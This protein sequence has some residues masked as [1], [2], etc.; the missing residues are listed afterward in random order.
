M[1]S[2]TQPQTKRDRPR[3]KRR[4][5]SS[6]QP[7]DVSNHASFRAENF[8]AEQA[9]WEAYYNSLPL[10][11]EDEATK[12]FN[13]EWV[14]H[15]SA[16]LPPYSKVLEAGCGAGWQSLAL[17]RTGVFRVSLMD[18]TASA[19]DYARRLFDREKLSADFISHNALE[20]GHPEFDLVF[21]AGVIEHYTFDQQ[22]EFVRAMASRSR[23]YVA[24]LAP[25]RLCYWYWLWRI[26]RAGIGQWPFGREVPLVDF[27]AMF[28]AAGIR[29]VGQTF[30]GQT[31]TEG[32]IGGADGMDPAFRH[33]VLQV[34][35]SLVIPPMHKAY[36]VAALGCVSPQRSVLPS[37]W[38][39][40]KLGEPPSQAEATAAIADAL[41]LR[42]AGELTENKLR[43]ELASQK[44]TAEITAAELRSSEAKRNEFEKSAAEQAANTRRA[45]DQAAQREH[46]LQGELQSQ[47]R[48]AEQI[49]ATLREREAELS[50]LAGKLSEQ[51][52]IAR[53][54]ADQIAQN[55]R[56]W[57][58]QK[59]Q[60]DDKLRA[61]ERR[62]SEASRKLQETS[63]LARQLV[64][65][66]REL[67]EGRATLEASQRKV[68]WLTAALAADR[69]ARQLLEAA[70]ASGYS[71]TISRIREVVRSS[72]PS[73]ATVLV[74]SRGDPELIKFDGRQAWHFPRSDNGNYAG[75]H[76]AE[77]EAAVAHLQL[78]IAQGGQ[79]LIVPNTAFWWLEHYRGWKEHLDTHHLRVWRDERC[80][81][82]KLS[83]I[84]ESKSTNPIE[85]LHANRAEDAIQ[86]LANG[87]CAKQHDGAPREKPQLAEVK[88][89]PHSSEPNG[90]AQS[91]APPALSGNGKAG[92]H[93][94]VSRYDV[95]CFPIINWDFRF[96]RPQQL[97]SQFAAAGHRVFYLSHNFSSAN[98]PCEV[99]L[100]APNIYEVFLQGPRINAYQGVLY[101][102]SRAAL[103]VSLDALRRD[104]ALGPTV[105]IV[106]LPFWWP[107]VK[108]AAAAF[109]WPV[110]YDCMD[111][112]AGFSTNHSVM[113]DQEQQ[114]LSE[115]FLA[116]V[117]SA[118]L[119]EEA[120]RS[121]RNVLLLRNAC[122]YGHFAT[123]PTK[124][125]KGRPVVGYYGAIA[126]WFDSDLVADLAERRSDW[127]FILVGSTFSA[128]VARLS[129]LPNVS[130]PGEKPYSEIPA[131]LAKFDVTILPFK[132]V[133]L[134]EAT[135]PVKAY[136]IFAAGKPLVS[137][138]LP[139][140]AQ[141]A[142]LARLASTAS[143]FEREIE[144]E[145]NSPSPELNAK[146]RSF[147]REN[148]WQKRFEVLA[149]EVGE[150][151]PRVAIIIVSYH[152]CAQLRQ[153]LDSIWAKTAYPNL[154]VV[155]V[156][157][158][159]GPDVVAY[160]QEESA[161]ESRLE[162]I[163]NAENVGFARANNIG[164]EA[165]QECEYVVLLNND[166]VVTRNWLSTLIRHLQDRGIGMV[167]PVTNWAGNEAKID[168]TYEGL[169]GMEEFAETYTRAHAGESF[170][171]SM[172][173]MYCVAF[174]HS[175]L[176]EI[177]PLDER[178]GIGMFEDDDFS[179]RVRCAGLRLVC[180]EEAFVHHWGRSS[181]GRL[182]REK[183]ERLF[184][185]NKRKF[186]EK[187]QQQWQPH[188]ARRPGSGCVA[189]PEEMSA[190][191][192]V[193]AL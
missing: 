125:K 138:P 35:R 80:A 9:K 142:P 68:E 160:L 153:C 97:M 65:V 38:T 45:L 15:V 177:G 181:F 26:Q 83:Q 81:I 12:G 136:E 135:N 173:A 34:H 152:N 182:E 48:S 70:A 148:T 145:L 106:Q 111:H 189:Q 117:S 154:K 123:I 174:R 75:H 54:T 82:Y 105:A 128:D 140:M 72:V 130:L 161:R 66:K 36:L 188:H 139:E 129:K 90:R 58:V 178:F 180:V 193:K 7:S 192:P 166:T 96:Q 21:N 86:T 8:N 98:E 170:E 190:A 64:G 158:A 77:S 95:V 13:R 126:E 41:A 42:I 78:L 146:R 141:L 147:A 119:E 57:Q 22:V 49:E 55:E 33:L 115:S 60:F 155:V 101:D 107:L 43:L 11:D 132:R 169:S 5:A 51:I 168:V 29:L 59:A 28:E 2:T 99:R 133:P 62:A 3:R 186:E 176:D 156:D 91:T 122:D 167:G 47:R 124:A 121:N 151:F 19:L 10:V 164:L 131:W 14:Q 93:A 172:L 79:F 171:I 39:T 4:S 44:Q 52:A 76:P 94:P 40:S 27:S 84:Q 46:D 71:D 112:H 69:R 187:W 56:A 179:M 23:K 74:V 67:S 37:C 30:L 163:F 165:A 20:A 100:I 143:D 113:L 184:E 63:Q 120:R 25:N 16:I 61:A 87:N 185:E 73:D 118:R 191:D 157:N 18:F 114:L 108:E 144:A 89:D 92:A 159:S 32:L 150:A 1:I 103:F 134:T 110:V 109:A 116:V 104:C 149:P 137:V 85:R 183:Y 88:A 31:W 50:N 6:I 175:L 53:Q 102:D 162:V 127:D 17:A 24:V